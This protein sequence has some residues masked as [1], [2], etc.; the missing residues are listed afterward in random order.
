MSDNLAQKREQ[1]YVIDEQGAPQVDMDAF[2]TIQGN[3]PGETWQSRLASLSLL[4]S[5]PGK[6][7]RLF[8]RELYRRNRVLNH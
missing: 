7:Y 1:L 3:S 6:S 5:L 8:N 2:I 4:R